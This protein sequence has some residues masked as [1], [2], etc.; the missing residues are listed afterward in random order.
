M[1]KLKLETVKVTPAQLQKAS[2]GVKALKAREDIGFFKLPER[3]NLWLSS[4][5]RARELRKTAKT[6]VVLGMGGSSL[7]GRAIHQALKKFGNTH[8]LLFIDNVDAERFWNWLKNIKDF[9]EYHWVIV[10][11]SGNTIETLT[12]A[13]CI[14][15]HLRTTGHK[16][17]ASQC[18]VISENEDNPLMGWA[19]KEGVAALEIPKDVGGRFSVLSPVGLLPAAFYGLNLKNLRT[20]AIWALEQDELLTQ[21]VAQAL[22]SFERDENITQFWSYADG[23][24]DFGFWT[25]QLWAESLGKSCDRKGGAAPAV[26][27]PMPAVGSS[28]Q[29]SILQQVMEGPRDKFLWFFRV[30]ESEKAGPIIERNLFDGQ[31]LMNGKSMGDLFGAMAVATRDALSERQVQSLTLQTELLEESSFGALLMLL[32]LVVG[33]VG[34]ALD[35]NSFDQPGVELGKKLA[36]K[37]LGA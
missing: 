19:K 5:N 18:T 12:M 21:L 27:T 9:S 37:I 8:E 20:G 4:E 31:S 36:R 2:A 15:Q 26:S 30:S 24:R 13:E 14:D 25:Q 17:M 1:W 28:D 16:R 3:E 35:I 29:H 10:S 34:E 6:L 33:S 22:A 23:L 11:K 7:G 32:Q